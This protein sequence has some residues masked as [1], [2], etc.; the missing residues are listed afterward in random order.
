MNYYLKQ[1]RDNTVTLMTD[2]DQP[3]WTFNSLFEAYS[4]C[5]DLYDLSPVINTYAS[6]QDPNC[7]ICSI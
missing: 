3:L 7:S 5:R 1:W 6:A 4:V 2:E